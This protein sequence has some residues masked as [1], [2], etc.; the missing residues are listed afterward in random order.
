MSD[1]PKA[2]ISQKT[3]SRLGYALITSFLLFNYFMY[4]NNGKMMI[5]FFFI[6]FFI[7]ILLIYFNFKNKKYLEDLDEKLDTDDDLTSLF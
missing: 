6:S 1:L 3:L 4:V 2:P 5:I 7:S